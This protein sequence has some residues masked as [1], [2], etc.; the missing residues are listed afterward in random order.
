MDY[1]KILLK[2]FLTNS[3]RSKYVLKKLNNYPNIKEYLD[4]RFYD[5]S[6]SYKE[7]LDRIKFKIEIRP[8]CKL[9]GANVK[10]KGLLNSQPTYKTYCSCSCAQKSEETRNKYKE[11]C[12][13]KYGVDNSFKDKQIQEKKRKS[14]MDH[15]G[16]I[17]PSKSDEI[18]EK[19][20]NTCLEKYG[21]ASLL[22]SGEIRKKIEI[23]NLEKYG[24]ITPLGNT[25]FMKAKIKEKYGVEY[26]T[27][28]PYVKKKISEGTSSL[29]CKR[30]KEKTCME[31]YGVPHI[32]MDE[33]IKNK[34]IE[35]R[36]KNHTFNTS[37]P[38]EEL[39]VYIKSKFPSVIRQYKDKE[40][41]PW[42]C[43]FYI[44]ELDYFIELNG[45]WTHGKHPYNPNSEDKALLEK[46]QT[47]ALSG[48]KYYLNAIKTWTIYDVNKRETAKRN[49]LNFKEVWS[50]EE[51]KEFIDDL[52]TKRE[53]P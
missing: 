29:K 9:C 46:M 11:K 39:Y 31:R 20:K 37:K 24:S 23:T 35:T 44:P 38:E 18:K 7:I 45:T 52:Y 49:N 47:K 48:H 36:R 5:Y 41:Y 19:I 34:K 21:A 3:G 4:N 30:K 14:L 32:S 1:D 13:Q 17:V 50:L 42:Q 10:Y 6:E 27:Q 53:I 15:Y 22:Q 2:I 33:D 40:R 8:T 28:I 51:G 25:E 12:I 16:V 26:S 43:D